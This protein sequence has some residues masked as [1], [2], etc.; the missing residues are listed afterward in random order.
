MDGLTNHFI[1]PLHALFSIDTWMQRNISNALLKLIWRT[2]TFEFKH[3]MVHK[4]LLFFLLFFTLVI[5]IQHKRIC[6]TYNENHNWLKGNSHPLILWSINLWCFSILIYWMFCFS[7]FVLLS[8]F[9]IFV[10]FHFPL[11]FLY[12]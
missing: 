3:Q 8:S 7:N 12:I 5:Y 9:I 11:L 2:L 6:F 1:R 4:N 10:L